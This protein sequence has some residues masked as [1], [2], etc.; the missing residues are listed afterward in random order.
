MNKKLILEAWRKVEDQLS[1]ARRFLGEGRVDGALYFVWIA[2]EN[3]VNTLKVSINGRYVKD[4]REESLI[5]LEYYAL[6]ILKRDYSK[7]M[8]KL[9]KY[10]IAAE[11]HP[12]TAIP[13]DYSEDDVI[14]YIEEVDELKKEVEGILKSKGVLE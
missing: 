14:K 8:E 6:G 12:Y 9:A 11:F 7:L 10:R 4:H 13:R 2:V 5:L 1:L 3:L